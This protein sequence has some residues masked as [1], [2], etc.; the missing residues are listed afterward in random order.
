MRTIEENIAALSQ[1]IDADDEAAAK[2]AAFQL[3]QGF[4]L[5]VARIADALAKIADRPA[6]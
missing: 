3:L 4:L 6:H 5:N 2:K 1:A